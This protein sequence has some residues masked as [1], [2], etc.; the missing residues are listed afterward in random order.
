MIG[1]GQNL[2]L[3]AKN[4][5]HSIYIDKVLRFQISV[6]SI[7]EMRND[8]FNNTFSNNEIYLTVSCDCSIHYNH[9]EN[10][11]GRYGAPF[12]VSEL[13]GRNLKEIYRIDLVRKN[14]YIDVTYSKLNEDNYVISG[15]R[16]KN[17]SI[18]YQ[19]TIT[20]GSITINVIIEYPNSSKEI[21]DNMASLLYKSLKFNYTI[22]K[23]ID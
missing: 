8:G 6:D 19:K 2:I 18:Y 3:K 14:K 22:I 1:F 20:D 4:S 5:N 12:I 7:L 10:D 23:T 15:Y 9:D 11:P 21:G 17:N 16:K 13:A